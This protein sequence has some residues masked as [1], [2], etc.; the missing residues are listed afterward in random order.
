MKEIIKILT[1]AL[2]LGIALSGCALSNFTTDANQVK[3]ITEYYECDYEDCYDGKYVFR[4][5]TTIDGWIYLS[6]GQAY[7]YKY[8]IIG[9]DSLNN[10]I[11]LFSNEL[12]FET[13]AEND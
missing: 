1:L 13:V 10:K 2:I 5:D 7:I 11:G 4:K 3:Q 6:G 9:R 12:I 8:L